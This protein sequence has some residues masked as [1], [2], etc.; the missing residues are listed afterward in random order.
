MTANELL[1]RVRRNPG[2]VH[3]RPQTS[4]DAYTP[5]QVHEPAARRR[6]RRRTK[7]ANRP[8]AVRRGPTHGV[9][10]NCVLMPLFSNGRATMILF[11]PKVSS[12]VKDNRD[13]RL[14]IF[15]RGVDGLVQHMW[16][17]APSN[18]WSSRE[19][20]GGTAWESL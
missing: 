3:A 13:T 2:R 7:S 4:A 18:G 6:W 5:Q 1:P 15:A 11:D 9:W 19:S 14:E 20:M 17:T 10:Q 16:Q 12:R 8:R